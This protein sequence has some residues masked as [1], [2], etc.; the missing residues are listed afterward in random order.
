LSR[1]EKTE[2]KEEGR[3]YYRR[4]FTYTSFYRTIPLPKEIVPSKAQAKYENGILIIRAPK[5]EAK[6]ENAVKVNVE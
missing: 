4:E 5:V 1:R 3:N 6:D 2:E